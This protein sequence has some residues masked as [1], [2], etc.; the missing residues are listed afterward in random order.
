MDKQLVVTIMLLVEFSL[1]ASSG[2]VKNPE[3]VGGGFEGDMVLS[4][5]QMRRLH[6]T[7]RNGRVDK[8]Y[9]WPKKDG[10]VMVLYQF[11]SDDDYSRF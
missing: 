9:R 1:R 2:V 6:Y 3:E 4:E 11:E 10:T 8:R 5:R 7:P